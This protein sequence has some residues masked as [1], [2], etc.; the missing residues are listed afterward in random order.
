[1]PALVIEDRFVIGEFAVAIPVGSGREER[2]KL[3]TDGVGP[4]LDEVAKS[5]GLV[6]TAVPHKYVR[7]R[8]GRDGEGRTVFDVTGFIDGDYLVP[9]TRPL[10]QARAKAR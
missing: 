4:L 8:P 1:M 6:V 2:E 5:S 7:E 10:A 3:V 9:Q